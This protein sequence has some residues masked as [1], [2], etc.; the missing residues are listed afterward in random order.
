M[1]F[2]VSER[3]LLEKQHG[4]CLPPPA[5]AIYRRSCLQPLFKCDTGPGTSGWDSG[6]RKESYCRN[7]TVYVCHPQLWQ[8]IAR[9]AC[10]FSLSV[11]RAPEQVDGIQGI[12]KRN[13]T[14]YVCHPQLWIIHQFCKSTQPS[15][16]ITISYYHVN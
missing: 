1:G 15:F 10:N 13:N 5:V 8:Y 12:G 11:K 6:Y 3:E 7:N 14:A 2:R 4:L 16:I 9:V